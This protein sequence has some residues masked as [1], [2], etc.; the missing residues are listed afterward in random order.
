[1]IKQSFRE[2]KR[3]I[4]F[5][6]ASVHS[7][8]V[9]NSDV[10]LCNS[11]DLHL[12]MGQEPKIA[13]GLKK[14]LGGGEKTIGEVQEEDTQCFIN[15]KKRFQQTATSGRCSCVHLSCQFSF[16]LLCEAVE[17]LV[18]GVRKPSSPLS[19]CPSNL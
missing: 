7:K 12:Y 15:K 1:M 3:K 11:V 19:Q 8:A 14:T 10:R 17:L 4:T 2:T 6:N 16:V 13:S 9:N 18:R 5:A